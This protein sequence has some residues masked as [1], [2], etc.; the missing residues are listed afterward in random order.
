MK[1]VC[2]RSYFIFPG[3][4]RLGFIIITT[5]VVVVVSLT[6][7]KNR[8]LGQVPVTVAVPRVEKRVNC[9]E[10]GDRRAEPNRTI[11]YGSPPWYAN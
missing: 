11:L 6:C 2:R 1:K 3:C 9:D 10:V 5:I 8:S 4:S 7:H